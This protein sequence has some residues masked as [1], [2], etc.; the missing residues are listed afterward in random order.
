MPRSPCCLKSIDEIFPQS[1]CAENESLDLVFQH[2]C[3]G[4]VGPHDYSLATIRCSESNQDP[5]RRLIIVDQ[6]RMTLFSWERAHRTGY[7]I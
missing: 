7:G 1:L 2:T 4:I 6:T 5:K 3:A